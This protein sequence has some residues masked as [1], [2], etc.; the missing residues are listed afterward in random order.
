ME[1]KIK[2]NGSKE[3]YDEFLYVVTQYKKI[4]NNPEKKAYRMTRYLIIYIL[5]VLAGMLL[6]GFMYSGHKNL[7]WA[8]LI[9]MYSLLLVY[10]VIYLVNLTKKIK[11]Y[12]DME[13]EQI[14]NIDD[15]GVKISS[16]EN[17]FTINWDDI[18]NIVVNKYSI[19]FIPK[20]AANF[21]M[22][23]S[24]EYID[25]V[26]EAIKKVNRE[27]LLVDNFDKFGH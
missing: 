10:L 1:F 17:A 12:I 16:G 9:G 27:S 15:K 8:A 24:V 13:D 19:C 21:L 18:A 3:F 5:F 26:V 23:V 4:K 2:N 25:N 6:F 20:T 11:T 22:S 14:I 7:I